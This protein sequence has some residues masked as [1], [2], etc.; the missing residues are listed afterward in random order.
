MTKSFLLMKAE[1]AE[2]E[3]DDDHK[4]DDID[5]AVHFGLPRFLISAGSAE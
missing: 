5:D 1:K 2:D 3:H 4:A